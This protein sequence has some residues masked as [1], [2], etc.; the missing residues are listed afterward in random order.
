MKSWISMKK[1]FPLCLLLYFFLPVKPF[2][3][4]QPSTLRSKEVIILFEDTLRGAAEEAMLIY[5]GVKKELEKDLPWR[6]HFTPTVILKDHH[7]FQKSAGGNLIVAYALSGRN[8]I[9]IDYSKMRAEPYSLKATMKHELC[10]LLLHHHIPRERLP[11]WLDE[12]IAQWVSGGMTEVVI[13]RKR[14]AL[15]GAVLSGRYIKLRS[16]TKHFPREEEFLMLAYE[17]S[18]S[19]VE[20]MIRRY[21]L[22]GIFDLMNRLAAGEDIDGAI[23]DSFSISLGEL[24]RAWYEDLRK[25]ITWLTYLINHLYEIIFFIAALLMII[26]FIRRLLKKKEHPPEDEGDEPP[27]VPLSMRL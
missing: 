14:S 21:G 4:S 20:Y 19:L 5:P 9:V 1:L 25:R 18:K 16:L 3:A 24:E 12:G 13:N 2:H 22:S 10:H 11:R 8:L 15:E 27:E 17:Q 7:S 23:L 26:G 6:I